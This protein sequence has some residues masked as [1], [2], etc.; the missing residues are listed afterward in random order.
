[1]SSPQARRSFTKELRLALGFLTLLPALPSGECEDEDVARSFAWF[2]LVGFA[3]GGLL[4]LEDVALQPVFGSALRS[5]L[6]ILSLTALTGAVHLDALADTADA[7]GAGRDRA[8]ALE[9]LRDSRVGSYGAI[10]LVFALGLKVA[11]LASLSG[12]LRYVALV[13]APGIGRWAMVEVSQG[14]EYLRDTGA[15]GTLLSGDSNRGSRIASRVTLVMLLLVALLPSLGVRA[16]SV[17]AVAAALVMALRWFYRRWLGGV[18]GDLIG[19]CGELVE[20]AVL[21]VFAA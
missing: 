19:A 9:I 8:R 20:V 12:S 1:M 10:A 16:L 7:L 3:I 14:L 2:P 11:A 17:T 6:V 5:M 4:C 18:T 13:V 15:G 21:I